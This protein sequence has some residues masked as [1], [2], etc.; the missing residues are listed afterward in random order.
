MTIVVPTC[1]YL[2]ESSAATPAAPGAFEGVICPGDE[3][4]FSVQ[5]EA[6]MVLSADLA[7]GHAEGDLNLF[8]YAE[9]GTTLLVAAT[10][11]DDDE[12]VKHLARQARVYL[13]VVDGLGGADNAY[14]LELGVEEENPPLSC[15]ADDRYEDNDGPVTATPLD[16]EPVAGIVCAWD[17]DWFAKDLQ[18]GDV[19]TVDLL[20]A[21]RRGG[22]LDLY[23]YDPSGARE[24]DHSRSI[25][26]DERVQVQVDEAGTYFVRVDGFVSAEN[27]YELRVTVEP[28]G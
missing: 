19:V 5:V 24:L 23:V 11:E 13:V 1:S 12:Q 20:Y 7:F 21:H 9:D 2:P 3:D 8:L 18:A 10:S 15:P 25:S 22:D 26:D 17:D 6:G 16:D 4:W 14:R 27:T 28:G